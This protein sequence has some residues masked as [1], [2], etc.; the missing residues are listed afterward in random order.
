MSDTAEPHNCAEK[1]EGKLSNEALRDE[2]QRIRRLASAL[3]QEELRGACRLAT[4]LGYATGHAD[5]YEQLVEHVQEQATDRRRLW[6]AI[7]ANTEDLLRRVDHD[8]GATTESAE[9]AEVRKSLSDARAAGLTW[10]EET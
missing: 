5:T 1:G 9:A 7:A 2:M 4:A 10:E 8:Y 3:E 6:Q